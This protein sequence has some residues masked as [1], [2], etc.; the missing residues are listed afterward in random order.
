[1]YFRCSVKGHV[2]LR[3][4]RIARIRRR[5][6]CPRKYG[7][8]RG[9]GGQAAIPP[10]QSA[11]V[12]HDKEWPHAAI[13]T[14]AEGEGARPR[15]PENCTELLDVF[16][17]AR[18]KNTCGSAN[19]PAGAGRGRDPSRVP[20]VAYDALLRRRGCLA[21]Q[22]SGR[23]RKLIGACPFTSLKIREKCW[24]VANPHSKAISPI[25]RFD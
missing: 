12:R 4:L 21:L 5:L 23:R 25:D 24:I 10:L 13:L 19:H 1:M 2:R 8:Y 3:E 6:S 20:T 16:T 17:F 22:Y 14:K 7:L 15:A 9:Y 18:S 11:R